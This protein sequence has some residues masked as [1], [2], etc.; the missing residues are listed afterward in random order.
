VWINRKQNHGD[1]PTVVYVYGKAERNCL[2]N[3]FSRA[4]TKYIFCKYYMHLRKVEI[5]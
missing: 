5:D 4:I 3:Q 2:S 1:L